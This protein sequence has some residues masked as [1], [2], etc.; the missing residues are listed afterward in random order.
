MLNGSD[1]R[2]YVLYLEDETIPGVKLN[3]PFIQIGVDQG[4]LNQPVDMPNGELVIAPENAPTL[5]LTS[6]IFL[7][8]LA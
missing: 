5:W 3:I 8:V 7:P 6:P 4:F 1:S 2:F